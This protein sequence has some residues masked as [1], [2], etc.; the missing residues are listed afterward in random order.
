MLFRSVSQ[1]RYQ[2]SIYD[3]WGEDSYVVTYIIRSL[4]GYFLNRMVK[5]NSGKYI[6]CNCGEMTLKKSNRQSMCEKCWKE[7]ESINCV[8]RKRKQRERKCHSLEN[9]IKPL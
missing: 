4:K 1:S 6:E 8:L 9:T 2:P 3:G 7:K 5:Y